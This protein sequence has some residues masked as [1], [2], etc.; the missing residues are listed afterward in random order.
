MKRAIEKP[1]MTSLALMASIIEARD[2]YTGGHLWRVSRYAAQLAEGYSLPRDM[3][4]LARLG[5]FMHDIGKVSIPDGVL[6]K[7]GKLTAAEYRVVQT[8][9]G[10]GAT[11]IQEHPLGGLALEAVHQHHEWFN[12]LGYPDGLQSDAIS[13]FARIVSIADAFD[14]LTSTRPYRS[15]VVVD[16]AVAAMAIERDTQFDPQLLDVFMRLAGSG[17]LDD[18]VGHSELGVAMVACPSCGPVITVQR[19]TRDGDAAFCRVCGTKHRLHR[20]GDTFVAEKF[21][22]DATAEDLK[23]RAEVNAIH[24]LVAMAPSSIDL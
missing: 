17:A 4:F 22:E 8:H 7:H 23:P 21:G 12:G 24:E 10:I 20:Q 13:I 16:A 2:A 1:L 11:L 15:Q 5:G 19:E 14:A 3:V 6:G 18:A 9:P